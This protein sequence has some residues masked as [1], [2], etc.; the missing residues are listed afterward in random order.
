MFSISFF[1]IKLLH[2]DTMPPAYMTVIAC[3]CS[4]SHT[5]CLSYHVQVSYTDET[6]SRWN[7]TCTEQ[8]HHASNY[9]A[10]LSA[11]NY[12]N[13]VQ[14]NAARKQTVVIDGNLKYVAEL[15]NVGVI[16][17]RTCWQQTWLTA[18]HYRQIYETINN[19]QSQHNREMHYPQ[20]YSAIDAAEIIQWQQK[21]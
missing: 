17:H 13:H 15:K 10:L 3:K 20:I 18:G 12:S 21:L 2:A 7:F 19:H 4:I 5:D 16:D 8:K 9:P 6:V 14:L 1:Q 11:I